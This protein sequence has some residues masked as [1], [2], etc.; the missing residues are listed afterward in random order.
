EYRVV[1][2]ILFNV[3]DYYFLA[4]FV[5]CVTT[6]KSFCFVAISSSFDLKSFSCVSPASFAMCMARSRIA[7]KLVM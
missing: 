2:I 3:G 1:G 7:L 4:F 6:S 5:G